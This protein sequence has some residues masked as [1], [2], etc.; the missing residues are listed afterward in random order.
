MPV[1]FVNAAQKTAPAA[2]NGVSVANA[3]GV[4]ATGAW[5]E[6]IASTANAIAL[7]AVHIGQSAASSGEMEIEIGVGAAGVEAAVGTLRFSDAGVQMVSMLRFGFPIQIA[8]G[9]RVA[10][11]GRKRTSSNPTWQTALSYYD[12]PISD[13]LLSTTTALSRTCPPGAN[14]ATVAISTTDWANSAWVEVLASTSAAWALS[15][16]CLRQEFSIS[17]MTAIE[18]DVGVGTAG[19]E[20]VVTK[21]RIGASQPG[22]ISGGPNHH[23]WRIMNDQIGNGQRVAVRARKGGTDSGNF[24]IALT[25]YHLPVP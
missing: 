1:E 4:W 12:L 18:V 7:T 22:D 17:A 5:F 8:A 2:A 11:R 20:T 3:I 13:G 9:A 21:M 16:L 15:A 6:I 25:H 14:G 19:N 24:Q 23:R 10:A